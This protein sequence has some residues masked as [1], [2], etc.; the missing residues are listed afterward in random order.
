MYFLFFSIGNGSNPVNF[1]YSIIDLNSTLTLIVNSPFNKQAVYGNAILSDEQYDNV[2]FNFYPNP[3]EDFIEINL[4]NTLTNNTTLE[5]YN[6]IG[7]LHKT[8]KIT[9]T[10][11]QI[12]TNDLASGI[13]FLKITSGNGTSVKKLIKK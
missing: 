10:K 9:A 11:T 7:T 3:S 4:K 2:S 13:Y 6:E 5:I 8:E 1:T 12:D